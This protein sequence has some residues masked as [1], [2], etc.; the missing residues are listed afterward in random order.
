MKGWTVIHK[1]KAMHDDGRGSSIRQIAVALGLSR[2]TVRKYLRA[3]V[4]EVEAMLEAPR[5]KV[6]DEHR[7]YL[8]HLLETY[9]RLSAVKLKRKLEARVGALDVSARTMRRYIQTLRPGVAEAQPRYY[10]PVLDEVPGQQCQVD[11]GELRAVV[12]NAVMTTVYFV[13]FVLSFS[14][15][16][17]VS[18]SRRPYDTTRFIAA[19]DEA[20][21]FFGGCPHECVYDQTK[22]VVLEEH[23][24]E[25]VL[26]ERFARYA[27]TA[28]FRIHA[29]QGYDPESKGKVEAGVKYVK[30]DGLYGERYADWPDVTA[31]LHRWLDHTANVRVHATTG[32]V[33]RMR[34]EARER[35]ALQPYLTPAPLLAPEELGEARAVDKTGLLSFR[36]NKYSVPMAWQ[37]K[38]VRVRIADEGELHI[39]HPTTGECIARHRLASGKGERIVNRDHYRDKSRERGQ[40]EAPIIAALGE[41][42]GPALCRQLAAGARQQYTDKLRGVNAHLERIAQLPEPLLRSLIERDAGLRVSTLVDYVRAFEAN[43]ER[44]Q[45]LM[46]S[47]PTTPSDTQNAA[48]GAYQGLAHRSAQEV[49]REFH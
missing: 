8:V 19:H 30:N 41:S 27:S 13:V 20:F 16:M 34:F 4:A 23:H 22:L 43:P 1:I 5:D 2:N 48:L 24:R 44:A 49:T 29:C 25:L 28:G 17:Y 39:H 38:R 36:A 31:V 35:A 40:L 46:L 26:N 15:L 32:E 3:E 37:R 33:P 21:R 45:A 42:L 10:A 6:L 11:G 18:V 7:D 12:V 9:P 47:E 14:R